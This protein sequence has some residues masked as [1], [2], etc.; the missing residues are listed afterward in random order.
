[1]G[2]LGGAGS[3]FVP[4]FNLRCKLRTNLSFHFCRYQLL[5]MSTEFQDAHLAEVKPLV[6]KEEV[7]I[8]ELFSIYVFYFRA[9]VGLAH[10]F[11]D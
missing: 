11:L 7:I 8:L 9:A 1:M 4:V 6:E 2:R 3:L 5:T 10:V